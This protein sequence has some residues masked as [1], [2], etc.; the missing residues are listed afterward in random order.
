MLRGMIEVFPDG[1]LGKEIRGEV[2]PLASGPKDVEDGI[3]DIAQVGRARPPA[4]IDGQVWFDQAPLGVG[5]V[6]GIGLGSHTP[7][8]EARPPC[9][10]DS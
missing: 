3:D 6:A 2:T 1:A 5:E 10:T 9:G 8:Y 7:F 4:R